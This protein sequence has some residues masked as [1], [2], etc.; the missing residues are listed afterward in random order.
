MF[1]HQIKFSYLSTCDGGWSSPSGDRFKFANTQN[2][3]LHEIIFQWHTCLVPFFV[4]ISL[5]AH[6]RL[7]LS[8]SKIHFSLRSCY[9]TFINEIINLTVPFHWTFFFFSA[10][11][12]W[13]LVAWFRCDFLIMSFDDFWHIVHETV[14]D[15]NCIALA[16]FVKFLASC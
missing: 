12:F 16:N 9:V 8:K 15:F 6:R 2:N 4:P 11:A 5:L 7:S 14:A 1:L 3:I 10:I 13:Y